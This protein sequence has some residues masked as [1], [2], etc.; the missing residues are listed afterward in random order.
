[1]LHIRNRPSKYPLMHPGSKQNV[2]TTA[3]SPILCTED[4]TR[5]LQLDTVLSRAICH[6][7]R[8]DQEKS[9]HLLC[10]H[11]L[12]ASRWQLT[13][14]STNSS[15]SISTPTFSEAPGMSLPASQ[16]VPFRG[17]DIKQLSTRKP[18]ME[19]CP[20]TTVTYQLGQVG[21][22]GNW[23]IYLS[24][25]HVCFCLVSFCLHKS[26]LC[27][28]IEK[29]LHSWQ[30]KAPIFLWTS[31]NITSAAH[32]KRSCASSTSVYFCICFTKPLIK[33]I[34]LLHFLFP[35][36]SISDIFWS[37]TAVLNCTPFQICLDKHLWLGQV[38]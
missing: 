5:W 25:I 21:N 27:I 15:P 4:T 30:R 6:L 22:K 24:R 16:A 7:S 17:S 2:F 35:F 38:H 1:M 11:L 37:L 20:L 26:A 19:K 34:M 36:A 23:Q 9:H 18:W 10:H 13:L 29:F 14:R 28:Y 33:V 32:H 8:G 3:A 31:L 12:H